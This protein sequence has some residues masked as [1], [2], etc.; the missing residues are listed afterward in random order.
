MKEPEWY[1]WNDLPEG[2][3]AIL[4]NKLEDTSEAGPPLVC[5]CDPAI[6]L[7]SVLPQPVLTVLAGVSDR[8]RIIPLGESQAIVWHRCV[9]TTL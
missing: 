3:R 7:D 5:L 9:G 4:E 8:I 6:V 2:I 1:L